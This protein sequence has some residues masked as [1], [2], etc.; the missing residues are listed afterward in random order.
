MTYIGAP[1]STF[2]I[3]VTLGADKEFSANRKD[4]SGNPVDWGAD[5]SMVIDRLDN[6]GSATIDA[7]VTADQAVVVIPSATCDLVKN[8]TTRWRLFMTTGSG[9]T[10][11]TTPIAVGYFERD[12]GGKTTP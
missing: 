2:I 3:P 6:G 1:A 11:T 5:L 12:D 4:S 9:G 10:A 8:N 7:T